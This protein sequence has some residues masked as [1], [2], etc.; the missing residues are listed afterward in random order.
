MRTSIKISLKFVPRDP[1]DNIPILIQIMAWRRP[2]DK[3]L[4][5]TMLVSLLK[6]IC[7]T[8]RQWVTPKMHSYHWYPS[9]GVSII[10]IIWRKLTELHVQRD[11]LYHETGLNNPIAHISLGSFCFISHNLWHAGG[12]LYYHHEIWNVCDQQCR[13]RQDQGSHKNL[14][15]KFHDFSMTSPGQNP[16]FKTKNINICFCGPCINL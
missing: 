7:I 5:E 8:H 9:H 1:I 13:N 3:P 16:N 11:A 4:P 10:V 15:K 6:Y 12:L 2:G 14:R